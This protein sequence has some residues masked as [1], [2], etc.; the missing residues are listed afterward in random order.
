VSFVPWP[1]HSP[2]GKNLMS[3]ELEVGWAQNRSRGCGEERNYLSLIG[4][5]T[6]DRPSRKV[7][8]TEVSYLAFLLNSYK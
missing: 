8:S 1:L 6:P 7:G 5:Q 3:T 4:I 2:G